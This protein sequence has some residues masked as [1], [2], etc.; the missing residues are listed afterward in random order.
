MIAREEGV[1]TKEHEG[2]VGGD[3]EEAGVVGP[4]LHLD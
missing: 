2:L 1:T 3:L 4:V